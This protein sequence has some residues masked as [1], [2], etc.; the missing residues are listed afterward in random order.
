LAV[1][2]TGTEAKVDVVKD[3]QPIS[4][5]LAKVSAVAQREVCALA[6][7]NEYVLRPIRDLHTRQT[8]GEAL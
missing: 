7:S 4:R 8:L 5:K 2:L 1:W 6:G 3:I